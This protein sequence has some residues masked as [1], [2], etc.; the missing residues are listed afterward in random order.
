MGHLMRDNNACGP[1]REQEL[2]R[3][4]RR[5]GESSIVEYMDRYYSQLGVAS[6]EHCTVDSILPQPPQV[7][8]NKE[9]RH[10]MGNANEKQV[11]GTHYQDV[12]A[13]GVCP[14]CRGPIQHWDWASALPG[15]E[16]AATKYLARWRLKKP[17]ESLEKVL[18]YVQKI[19][20]QN[21]PG[22]EV[23]VKI[24]RLDQV[25]ATAEAVERIYRKD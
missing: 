25:S 24:T 7:A 11:G 23:S 19:I 12:N 9:L 10:T 22:V 18:H 5:Y 8:L 20:E 17:L 14:H 2:E 16:Y 4:A 13:T 21:F 1:D 15:L 6:P 3:V